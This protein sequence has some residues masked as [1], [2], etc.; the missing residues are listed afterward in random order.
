MNR[1]FSR[2]QHNRYRNGL[3]SGNTGVVVGVIVLVVAVIALLRF[4]APGTLG[5]A[6]TPLWRFGSFLSAHV[7]GATSRESKASLLSDRDRLM[8]ENATLTA[9]NAAR[10][11][12]VAD[13]TKLLGSRT[14]PV[15]GIVASV[16][17]RPPVAPYDVL[18][19]D[20]GTDAGVSLGARAAGMGGTPIGTVG[21][22]SATESR[23]TLY[24]TH[25]IQTGGWAGE[26]HIPVML[27]GAGAGAFTAEVPKE[28]GVKVGDGVYVASAGAFPI[29]T[30]VHIESDP[31]SPSVSLDV[32]PYTNPFSL[33]WV[34]IERQ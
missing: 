17:A 9:Q 13:L 32:R 27:T 25:G 12:Q 22:V 14:E 8:A 15:K 18:I 5:Q 3:V 1:P 31:S 20:Q 2:R 4:F 23:I 24:S 26:E 19:T 10:A 16:R 6:T 7:R 21:Q 33:T 28:A 29:G 30:V 34:T 11:V